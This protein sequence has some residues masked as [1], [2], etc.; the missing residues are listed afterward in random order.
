MSDPI[1]NYWGSSYDPQTGSGIEPWWSYAKD[2]DTGDLGKLPSYVL[3]K[4]P[5]PGSDIADHVAGDWQQEDYPRGYT[6]PYDPSRYV[7]YTNAERGKYQS[8]ST[9]EEDDIRKQEQL[10]PVIN[11]AMALQA[12]PVRA[13]AGAGERAGSA[14]MEGL[15]ELLGNEAGMIRW[16]RGKNI[17]MQ[18]YIERLKN[19][20]N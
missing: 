16:E 5:L 8:G 14:F 3:G 12:L 7:P 2:L 6:G 9:P 19:Q 18:C 1:G 13:L 15:P 11:A 20:K 17:R 4:L 10:G